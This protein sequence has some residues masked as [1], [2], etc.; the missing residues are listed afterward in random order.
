VLE[1]ALES[2]EDEDP[3][4]PLRRRSPWKKLLRLLG[5]ASYAAVL[6]FAFG[7]V[8]YGAFNVFVRRGVTPV[9]ELFGLSEEEAQALLADQG[10][11]MSGSERDDR[12]DDE[13]PAGHV[14]LQ[15]PR[16]GTLVKRESTV[17]V[18]LSR[19][20]QRIEVPSVSGVATQAAQVTLAAA[21]LTVGRTLG[22]WSSA[23]PPGSVVAQR[24]SAGSLVERSAP[25][26]LFVVRESLETYVMPDLVRG[27]YERVRLFFESRGF[28]IGRVSYETYAGLPPGTVLRQFP[29]AGHPLR[30]GD[31]ISLDVTNPETPEA[32]TAVKESPAE[33]ASESLP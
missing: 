1:R 16:A 23:A 12:Y 19:G 33:T 3:G 18:V 17:G 27:D 7:A 29:Q 21:D 10:L 5:C 6:A 2:T 11:D 22:V 9:P 4:A 25:I 14:V 28:R 31:V 13:V 8:A 30:R 26:D 24:P 15:K 20:P 32:G